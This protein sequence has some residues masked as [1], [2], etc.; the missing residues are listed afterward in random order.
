[1]FFLFV[2]CAAIEEKLRAEQESE[3]M[4][5]VLQREEA[6]AKRKVIEAKGIADF[7]KIV[8][9]GISE[10]LLRWKG[11]EGTSS[12]SHPHHCASRPD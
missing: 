7:Q 8:T 3:R 2:G 10:Q 1:V 4:S 12:S 11:I 6:E 5:W 9:Q